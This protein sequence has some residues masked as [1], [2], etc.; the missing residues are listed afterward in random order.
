MDNKEKKEMGLLDKS[1]SEVVFSTKVNVTPIYSKDQDKWYLRITLGKDQ[2][3]VI[4][5]TSRKDGKGVCAMT[6]WEKYMYTG[7]RIIKEVKA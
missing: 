3:K 5:I 6:D 1:I 7:N 4:L 2:D